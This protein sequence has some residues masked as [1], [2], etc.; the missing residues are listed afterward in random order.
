MFL[1]EVGRAR[2]F[3]YELRLRHAAASS[4]HIGSFQESGISSRL[5]IPEVV[6][7]RR[8]AGS[9]AVL[10]LL[11][12]GAEFVALERADAQADFALGW[13]ELDDLHLVALTHLQL[14]FL[15]AVRVVEL[16]T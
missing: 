14:D 12:I 3:L 8:R 1:R 4:R 10:I 15:A 7:E 16:E 13:D 9:F 11:P 2:H 6:P 5:S